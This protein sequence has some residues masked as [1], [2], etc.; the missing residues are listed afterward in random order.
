MIPILEYENQDANL[1]SSVN[2]KS[3]WYDFHIRYRVKH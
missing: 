2:N 3:T 1:R